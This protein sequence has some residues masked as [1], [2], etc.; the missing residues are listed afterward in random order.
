MYKSNGFNK[1][2]LDKFKVDYQTK[3]IAYA[4]IDPKLVYNIDLQ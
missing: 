3:S 4:P 2:L 1:H